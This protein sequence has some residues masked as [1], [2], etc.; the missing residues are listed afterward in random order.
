M[1][2]R[3][4]VFDTIMAD[5]LDRVAGLSDPERVG[6][7]LGITHD[8]DGYR[9]PFYHREY[10]V[11]TDAIVDRTYKAPSHA[12][13]VILCQYL[14]LCPDAASTDDSLVTYK[15]FRDAG[16]YVGGF[17]NT[18]EQPIVRRFSGQT[19][20]LEQH[21]RALG[22][23]PFDTD[24]SCQL[25]Y[26]FQAL[27]RVPLFL[28]FHDADDDFPAQCTPLFQKNAASYLDMECLA[29]LGS[30]LSAWLVDK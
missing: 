24:V 27:P 28:L 13:G 20:S 11:S 9:I 21:C 30:T 7:A 22:G 23:R 25:A 4:A 16:P 3:A 29:M 17:K 14:L 26:R 12:T 8:S 15:D 5:Y 2:P 19:T 1:T 6:T 10:T 18:T